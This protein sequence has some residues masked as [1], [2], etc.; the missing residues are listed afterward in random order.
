ME[1]KKPTK[2]K[3]TEENKVKSEVKPSSSTLIA[4][5]RIDG[6]VKVK[7]AAKFTL[8][9]MRLKK[10][11]SCVLVDSKN[12]SIIGMLDRVKHSV[13]Y[14]IIERDTLVKLL[15]AR[16]EKTPGLNSTKEEKT[17]PNYEAIA[18]DLLKGKKLSELGFKSFFRLHPPRKGINSKLQ[19]P[20]GVLG[21]NKHDINKLIERML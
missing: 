4:V 11:Y 15:A 2:V 21:N 14:G 8:E 6:E 7:P 19:Y 20:K 13:A 3:K 10:K 5:V 12:V 1:T 9:R 16:L 18:E 17:K